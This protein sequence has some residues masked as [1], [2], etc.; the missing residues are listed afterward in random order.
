LTGSGIPSTALARPAGFVVSFPAEFFTAACGG[1]GK[2]GSFPVSGLIFAQEAK[3]PDSKL[4]QNSFRGRA[5]D[6]RIRVAFMVLQS[7]PMEGEG[8]APGVKRKDLETV[9]KA[10]LI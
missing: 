9:P 3:L 2:K 10:G 1:G 6:G 7:F 5:E 8:I 4:R